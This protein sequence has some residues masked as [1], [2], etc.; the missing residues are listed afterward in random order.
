MLF[1]MVDIAEVPR[2]CSHKY[3]ESESFSF[4]LQLW[5]HDSTW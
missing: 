4:A 2:S 3:I 1:E 5:G